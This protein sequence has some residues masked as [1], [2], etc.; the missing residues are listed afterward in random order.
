MRFKLIRNFKIVLIITALA[1]V[2]GSFVSTYQGYSS[3]GI[4]LWNVMNGVV[5]GSLVAFLRG[6]RRPLEL[7]ALRVSV[8]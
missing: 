2:G 7:S 8:P 4:T 1:A 3:G 6:K 5:D